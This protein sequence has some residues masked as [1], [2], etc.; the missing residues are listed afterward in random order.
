[1]GNKALFG[2]NFKKYRKKKGISQKEFA[3]KLLDATG[4]D[5]TLTSIS[6]YE[7]GLHMP[8][9]QILPAIAEILGVS[10]DALF[11]IDQKPVQTKPS[12]PEVIRKWKGELEK[13]EKEFIIS[14]SK[15]PEGLCDQQ[16]KGAYYCESLLHLTKAQQEE[17]VII[18]TELSTIQ[19]LISLF[20]K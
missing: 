6:N 10:I 17:L 19:E 15:N 8:P 20:K 7:T 9:P 14:K 3:R 1:M 5:L 18:Q 2:N 16:K 12:G 11:G 4:K 13:I